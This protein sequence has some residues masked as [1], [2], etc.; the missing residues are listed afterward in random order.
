MLLKIAMLHPLLLELVHLDLLLLELA[1]LDLPLL[2]A[3]V[4]PR[5]VRVEAQAETQVEV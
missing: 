5:A 1:H 2:E 4:S 3:A